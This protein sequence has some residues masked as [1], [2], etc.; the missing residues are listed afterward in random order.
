MAEAEAWLHSHRNL[1]TP[2]QLQRNLSALAELQRADQADRPDLAGRPT[3]TPDLLQGG[4]SPAEMQPA[5][6]AAARSAQQTQTTV[7]SSQ[8]STVAPSSDKG[9]EGPG[10]EN[11]AQHDSQATCVAIPTTLGSAA[12]SIR[13]P[14]ALQTADASST[15]RDEAA[16]D[17]W[18]SRVSQQLSAWWQQAEQGEGISL[19]Q[20]RDPFSPGLHMLK[21]LFSCG[22]RGF[23]LSYSPFWCK[24]VPIAHWFEVLFAKFATVW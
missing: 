24:C 16:Q 11:R 15:G 3:Q 21:T 4:S 18:Y 1:L 9:L 19:L 20:V 14:V 2:D 10:M 6:A 13:L 23:L 22:G 12:D 7:T 8:S 5:G 17:S